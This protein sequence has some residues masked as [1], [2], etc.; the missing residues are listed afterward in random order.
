MKLK[1]IIGHD[2]KIELMIKAYRQNRLAHAYLFHGPA[3]IGKK[4]VALSVIKYIFCENEPYKEEHLDSCSSCAS[5]RKLESDNH[6]DLIMV[7]PEN[8]YIKIGVIRE[9]RKKLTF[10]KYDAKFKFCIINDAECMRA[11]P[12]NALL[13]TLE[14]P[15]GDVVIILITSKVNMLLP[16]I[17]SRCQKLR[18]NP[19]KNSDIKGE[20][21]SRYDLKSDEADIVSSFLQGSFLKL[22]STDLN[23]MVK[24]RRRLIKKIKEASIN[25]IA[26]IVDFSSECG[27]ED[28]ELLVETI[29]MIKTFYRDAAILKSS[30][31]EQL[32]N[33]DIIGDIKSIASSM[34]ADELFI[35][36]NILS[37]MQGLLMAN[38]NKRL[39]MESMMIELCA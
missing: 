37:R 4:A 9:L 5:C 39:V 10:G 6:P 20:L 17:I 14:E 30:A 32:I 31:E 29:E 26:G 34:T 27:K 2:D 36:I 35:K 3:G 7:E 11:E 19:L 25:N 18:F 33:K 23:E 15:S 13:K 28:K 21:V 16:T 8:S 38:V 24:L 12:A 22:D 1:D